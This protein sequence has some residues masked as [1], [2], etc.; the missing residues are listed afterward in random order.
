MA[1]RTDLANTSPGGMA[2]RFRQRL[3]Q[4]W[5]GTRAVSSAPDLP[6]AGAVE[7]AEVLAAAASASYFSF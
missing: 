5:S 2:S 4:P 3:F 1:P 7:G 6:F